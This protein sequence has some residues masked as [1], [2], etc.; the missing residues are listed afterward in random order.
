M[1]AFL[2]LISK[3]N[4]LDQYGWRNEGSRVLYGERVDLCYV[5]GAARVCGWIGCSLSRSLLVISK[6][7]KKKR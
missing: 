1:V 5:V 6:I 2:W 7:D 4:T 3:E